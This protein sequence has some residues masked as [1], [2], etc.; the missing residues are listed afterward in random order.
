M[1]VAKYAAIAHIPV[2][3][4]EGIMSGFIVS[5]LMKVRPEILART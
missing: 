3:I 5:F 4:I 2:I 1:G